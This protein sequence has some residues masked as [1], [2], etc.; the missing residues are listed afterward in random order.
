LKNWATKSNT[1]LTKFENGKGEKMKYFK[2]L[3][4]A[5][6][7][8]LVFVGSLSYSAIKPDNAELNQRDNSA[9]QLTADQQSMSKG[10]TEITRKIRRDLTKNGALSIYAQNVKIITI[11]GRVT[12]K[13]PV[14]SVK[15]ERIILKYAH[16]TNGVSK[17]INQL[18]VARK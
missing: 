1:S 15:E 13:G 5:S 16:S 8:S 3:S 9:N 17:V 14:R 11:D 12:V 2:S 7:L 6:I 4:S 18:Q 10:D